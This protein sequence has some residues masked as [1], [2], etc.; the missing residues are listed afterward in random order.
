MG[1]RRHPPFS[2]RVRIKNGLVRNVFSVPPA[3]DDILFD[4]ANIWVSGSSLNAVTKI[5]KPWRSDFEQALD[6]LTVRVI[7]AIRG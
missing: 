7:R 3:P 5:S 1:R 6:I 2:Y 4:G